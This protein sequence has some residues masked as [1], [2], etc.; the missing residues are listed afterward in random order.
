[1]TPQ[2]LNIATAEKVMH[3]KYFDCATVM[4]DGC[5]RL[6]TGNGN[7]SRNW[8]P[9]GDANHAMEL[10]GKF[11]CWEVCRTSVG[12]TVLITQLPHNVRVLFSRTIMT[13][14]ICLAALTAHEAQEVEE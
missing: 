9:A 6:A 7:E 8:N 12:F 10:L 11:E 13:E 4:L 3:Y 5:L 14:A 2:E 1:M